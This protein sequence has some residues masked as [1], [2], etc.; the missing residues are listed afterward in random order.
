[1]T[2][3]FTYRKVAIFV[4]TFIKHKLYRMFLA[5]LTR[6]FMNL[7]NNFKRWRLTQ[8]LIENYNFAML[9]FICLV[10]KPIAR[11]NRPNCN[12]QLVHG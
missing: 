3:L 8:K 7:N 12:M 2:F 11:S 10:G 6:H 5:M 1:M 4:L 9:L